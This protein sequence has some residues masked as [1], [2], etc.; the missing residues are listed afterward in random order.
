MPKARTAHAGPECLYHS[1]L[2]KRGWTPS[3]ITRLLEEPDQLGKN[4]HYRSGPPTK[5]YLRLRVEAAEL[6]P[7]FKA[8][9]SGRESRQAS[10]ARAVQTKTERI[11]A[12]IEALNIRLPTLGETEL[13]AKAV[14]NR[15]AAIPEWKIGE[16]EFADVSDIQPWPEHDSFRDRICV[17]F[18]RHGATRYDRVLRAIRGKVARDEAHRLLSKKIFD[19]I[20]A[21][22]PKL[23]NEANR[24]Y[25]AKWSCQEQDAKLY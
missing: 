9:Q 7:E 12:E 18:L 17:N 23:A 3:L 24:Q 22:Y 1:T 6:L 2:L 21:S 5:L 10:A 4:P 13:I 16:V 19:A 25:A 8:A 20:A 14:R 11:L 15:N